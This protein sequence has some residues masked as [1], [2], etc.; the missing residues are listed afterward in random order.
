MKHTRLFFLLIT[1]LLSGLI[2]QA[3]Q[4]FTAETWYIQ[5]INMNGN[6]YK[7]P[8]NL[9]MPYAKLYT[10]TDMLMSEVSA[11]GFMSSITYKSNNRFHLSNFHAFDNTCT[12]SEN[13]IFFQ[14]LIDF[15]QNALEEDFSYTITTYEMSNLSNKELVIVR[16]DGSSMHATNRPYGFPNDLWCVQ[17][18]IL[19]KIVWQGQSFLAPDNE[20]VSDIH[21]ALDIENNPSR[22]NTHVCIM[23][24]AF[25]FLDFDMDGHTMKFR[26]VGIM[27]TVCN[28][29]YSS[30]FKDIYFS[31]LLQRENYPFHITTTTLPNHATQILL[32][33]NNHNQL[34]F[35][36]SITMTVENYEATHETQVY[37]NPAASCIHIQSKDINKAPTQLS[38]YSLQGHMVLSQNLPA[39][40]QHTIDVSC[41]SSGIYAIVLHSPQTTT[42][43]KISI[44]N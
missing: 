36:T 10:V 11:T 16:T 1:S 20:E 35:E 19:K 29:D 12:N 4:E 30:Q 6:S 44:S 34:L 15:F 39:H 13:Q 9:E 7:M 23:A 33:D 18:P 3:Q 26:E 38:I 32:E 21:L 2:L 42:I 28:D 27:P 43:H 37:P 40:T 17:K 8:D 41:L 24:N 5:Q 14:T 22:F 25:G 31:I